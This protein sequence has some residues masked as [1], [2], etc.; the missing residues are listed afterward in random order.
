MLLPA[1]MYLRQSP[2][3]HV[4]LL[5]GP[6]SGSLWGCGGS[7]PQRKLTWCGGVGLLP[8]EPAQPQGTPI[9]RPATGALG[10]PCDRFDRPFDGRAGGKRQQVRETPLLSPLPLCAL[11]GAGQNEGL[12]P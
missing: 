1:I 3:Y 11:A 6:E 9:S 4:I 8:L 5:H 12:V 10:E 2:F 7:F